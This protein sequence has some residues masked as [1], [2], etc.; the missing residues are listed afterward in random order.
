MDLSILVYGFEVYISKNST[1]G[2]NVFDEI[3]LPSVNR[4]TFKIFKFHDAPVKKSVL[5]L[6]YKMSKYPNTRYKLYSKS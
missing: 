4:L 5:Y 1:S 6:V 2:K 3:S